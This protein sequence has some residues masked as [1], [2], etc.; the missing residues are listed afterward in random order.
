MLVF[1]VKRSKSPQGQYHIKVMIKCKENLVYCKCM[2]V[3]HLVRF[4]VKG[5][6][7][8]TCISVIQLL[9]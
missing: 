4:R 3:T 2:R 5:I 7:V 6:L 9:Y 1:Q 8:D